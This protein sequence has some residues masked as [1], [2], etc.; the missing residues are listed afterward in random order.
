MSTSFWEN[1]VRY[2]VGQRKIR[3]AIL[4]VFLSIALLATLVTSLYTYFQMEKVMRL[5]SREL[6]SKTQQVIINNTINYLSPAYFI[7]TIAAGIV[8][9]DRQDLLENQDL[10]HF[11]MKALDE[12]PQIDAFYNGDEQGNTLIVGRIGLK[13]YYAFQKNKALPE[14]TKYFVRIIN[15]SREFPEE[16]RSYYDHYGQHLDWEKTQDAALFD[17]RTRPWYRGTKTSG[18][19]YRTD[20]YLYESRDLG[21]TF[22]VPVYDQ[23]QK[24]SA[25]MSADITVSQISDLLHRQKASRSGI[26][27]IVTSQGYL[28]GYPD[29]S[30]VVLTVSKQPQIAHLNQL[31]EPSLAMAY[32]LY[33]EKKEPHLF[34]TLDGIDYIAHFTDFPASLGQNWILGAVVPADDFIGPI[35]QTSQDVL[36]ISMFILAVA[37]LILVIFSHKISYPIERLAGQMRKIRTLEIEQEPVI[38][39]RLQELVQ[40]EEALQA[41]KEGLLSFSKFVPKTLV[42]RLIRSGQEAKLGGERKRLTFLFSDIEGFTS[43]SEKLPSDLLIQHLSLYLNELSKIIIHFHG[44]IDKYIGDSIMAFWGAPDRDEQQ[45]FHACQ[46]VWNCTRRL[47]ELNAEWARQNLPVFKTRFGLHQG[48]A[49]VGNV[50]SQ[51]RLNYTV[52][53]DHVNLASRLE[54]INKIYGTYI[55]VSESIYEKAKDKFLFRLIDIVA[56]K[57]KEKGIKVYQM[58]G[59]Y[60]DAFGSSVTEQDVSLVRKTEVAFEAYVHQ[61]WDEAQKMYENIKNECPHDLLAQLYLKRIEEFKKNPPPR[62]GWDGVTHLLT[63]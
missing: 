20:M 18:Q 2:L 21:L 47:E 52:I 15:R 59:K 5:T 50:G 62:E 9:R 32:Q 4:S 61:K 19:S 22:A 27:F 45:I 30:K 16:T 57:G 56:V 58:L 48:D 37:A 3:F 34:F 63:K 8:H 7:P 14:K 54:G 46:A 51:D 26:N 60:S 40:M 55:L 17:P 36:V 29:A 38:E 11:L 24:F 33:R 43:I 35:K 39:S 44:T 28:V 10:S 12:F 41:M 49:I 42:Q 1:P 13:H 53:G 23:T 6:I 25:V 31:G